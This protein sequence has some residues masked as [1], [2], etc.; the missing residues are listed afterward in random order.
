M[1]HTAGAY[2]GYRSMKR[3]GVFLLPPGWDASQGY[4]PSIEVAGTHLHTWVKRGTVRVKR[5]AQEHNA[6]PRPRLELGSFDPES[7]AL[8]IRPPRLPQKL[9]LNPFA[10]V[11]AKTGRD[12]R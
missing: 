12:R 10:S 11:P 1:A 3:L 6:V 7:S 9:S 8:T 2:P 4:P 5:L